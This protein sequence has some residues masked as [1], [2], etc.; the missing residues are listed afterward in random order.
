MSAFWGTTVLYGVLGNSKQEHTIPWKIPAG[1][2][3][4]V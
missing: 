4:S 2:F 1:S 3:I